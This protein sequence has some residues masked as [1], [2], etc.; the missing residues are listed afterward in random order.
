MMY[1]Q[2]DDYE[3]GAG[4]TGVELSPPKLLE[5]YGIPTP[6]QRLVCRSQCQAKHALLFLP[7]PISLSDLIVVDVSTIAKNAASSEIQTTTFRTSHRV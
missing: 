3:L 6:S 4:M 1:I 2:H 5:H 7:I